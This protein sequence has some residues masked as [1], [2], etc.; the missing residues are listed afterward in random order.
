MRPAA[1]FFNSY[2]VAFNEIAECR[3]YFG[4]LLLLRMLQ[5]YCIV[6]LYVH[7]MKVLN[8]A[9]SDVPSAGFVIQEL[10]RLAYFCSPLPINC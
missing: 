6:V 9:N 5:V 8:I 2:S 10:A 7:R 4:L 3:F 1:L